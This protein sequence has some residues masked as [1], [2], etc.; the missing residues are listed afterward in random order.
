MARRKGLWAPINQSST[1]AASGE[2]ATNLLVN[3]PIDL[4]AIGGLTVERI[5]GELHYRC[6]VVGTYQAFSAG[7][8]VHHEDLPP[9]DLGSNLSSEAGDWMWQLHT[10]TSGI[11]VEVA[12]GDFDGVD[13]IRMIDVRVARIVRPQHQ[14][15]M[16][17]ANGAGQ[18]INHLIGLRTYVLLP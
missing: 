8:A 9:Q 7:I 1:L 10:R 12:A 16:V 6:D 3:L 2:S 13:E 11:F 14:L 17:L 15:S 4:E 18:A 5:V